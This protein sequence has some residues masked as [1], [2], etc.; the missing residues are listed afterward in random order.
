MK[1]KL[2]G[3]RPPTSLE[4]SYPGSKIH[5]AYRGPTWGQQDP[6][7][8]PVGSI[9]LAIRIVIQ[10]ALTRCDQHMSSLICWSQCY[11]VCL[12]PGH[13]I[14]G[15][16]FLCCEQAGE[17]MIESLVIWDRW[18]PF[19]DIL[20]LNLPITVS[21]IYPIW[22]MSLNHVL[23]LQITFIFD[24]CPRKL[25]ALTLAQY[26]H[27]LKSPPPPPPPPP[28]HTHKSRGHE[29]GIN[30]VVRI[31][32]WLAP[33]GTRPSAGT[34]LRSAVTITYLCSALKSIF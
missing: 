9:N 10:K 16:R 18:R 17:Q 3:C 6:G 5:R 20:I 8:P 34:V 15:W 14:R 13:I 12:V 4:R 24:T 19:D 30:D 25:T 2:S 32:W 22:L 1:T 29:Q 23:D 31:S 26:E 21:L 28:T 11:S 7:G 33:D 27:V